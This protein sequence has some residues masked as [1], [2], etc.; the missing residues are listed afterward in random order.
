MGGNLNNGRNCSPVNFNCN[1]APSNSN[2]NRAS[3]NFYK[4]QKINTSAYLIPC[5]LAKIVDTAGISKRIYILPRIPET[6][7]KMENTCV[8]SILTAKSKTEK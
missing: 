4:N 7:K 6:I 1:N 3:R 8:H 5:R 2:W